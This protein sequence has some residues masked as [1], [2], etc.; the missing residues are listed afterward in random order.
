VY[1]LFVTPTPSPPPPIRTW[2]A[3]LFSDF[4]EEKT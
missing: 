4:L 1:T 2:S 3:L